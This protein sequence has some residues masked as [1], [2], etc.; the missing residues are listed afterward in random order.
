MDK[1]KTIEAFRVGGH[2]GH[3]RTWGRFSWTNF[4]IIVVI[5]RQEIT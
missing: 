2:G 3:G 4:L 1:Q 5:S